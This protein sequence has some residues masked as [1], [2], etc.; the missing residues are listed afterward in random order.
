[1]YVHLTDF[2][3]QNCP[4]CFAR[5]EMT[6]AVKKEMS[7]ED[8][9]KIVL[10][11]KKTERLTLDF[12]GGEPTLHTEFK[13]F[14]SYA[15]RHFFAIRLYTNGLFSNEVKKAIKRNA[16]RIRLIVNISTP[17]FRFNRKTREI[18]LGNVDELASETPV[19]LSVVS[20]FL[21]DSVVREYFQLVPRKILK[22]TSIKLSFMSPIAGDKNPISINDY[23]KIGKSIC[24]VIKQL[25]KIGPP[26]QFR[27]NKMFRPCM[28]SK[29]DR[30]FLKKRRLEFITE[31]NHCH[32]DSET[33]ELYHV[34]TDLST[35]KC[36]PLST[37]DIFNFREIKD[38][39]EIK[40]KYNRLQKKYCQDLILPE[41]KKCPFFGFKEGKC[42]GPCIGFRIN[43]LNGIN[44]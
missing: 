1:M 5:E 11:F 30:L 9:R 38:E 37:V 24:R 17:G 18:I 6:R 43:A 10:K 16:P 2:C 44:I 26:R 8:F 3:N 14:L 20:L 29:E 25:V 31:N 28:F 42:T 4:F 23:P 34:N 21:S 39:R 27:F 15:L 33:E 19:T 40:V 32:S 13:K 7:F 22:K 36:Y 41:C 12:L 35:F